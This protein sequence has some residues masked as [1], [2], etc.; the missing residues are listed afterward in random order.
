MHVHQLWYFSKWEFCS[1]ACQ[2]PCCVRQISQLLIPR[3]HPISSPI[4]VLSWQKLQAHHQDYKAS[5]QKMCL[6]LLQNCLLVS[7]WLINVDIEKRYSEI[8][9]CQQL[10]TS[11]CF[12]IIKSSQFWDNLQFFF[13]V[14]LMMYIGINC[15]LSIS[16][17]KIMIISV[18]NVVVITTLQRIVRLSKG[19]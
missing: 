12:L 18:S 8:W 10:L 17:K 16:L 7:H 15:L 14:H 6:L 4:T 2:E 9:K 19:G 5:R 13:S 11:E 1:T 3:P